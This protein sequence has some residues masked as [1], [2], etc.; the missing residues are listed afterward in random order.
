MPTRTRQDR[1]SAALLLLG[2][3]GLLASGVGAF[4][5]LPGW[6]WLAVLGCG[7]ARPL[8]ARQAG[9]RRFN[10]AELRRNEK[11]RRNLR[12]ARRRMVLEGE[13]LARRVDERLSATLTPAQAEQMVGQ[14]NDMA[15]DLTE[16]KQQLVKLL[17]D[18]EVLMRERNARGLG[19]TFGGAPEEE[20]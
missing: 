6:V 11:A 4:P 1:L 16:V 9:A 14:H 20:S 17:R 7:V 8:L 3:A 12:V 18:N 15:R 5:G 19:R 13:G 2:M 10:R